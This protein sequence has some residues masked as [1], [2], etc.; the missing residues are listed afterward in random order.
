[1]QEKEE[2]LFLPEMDDIIRFFTFFF[3]LCR[4]TLLTCYSFVKYTI[5]AY[6]WNNVLS[7]STD[8]ICLKQP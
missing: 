7:A 5:L 6:A 2:R 8:P 1:M 3:S 4:K